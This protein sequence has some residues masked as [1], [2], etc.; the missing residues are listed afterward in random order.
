M[1]RTSVR[2][3][4]S[5]PTARW[6]ALLPDHAVGADRADDRVEEDHWIDPV[7]RAGLPVAH[8]LQHRVGD[9]GN[10]VG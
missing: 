10:Q 1:P 5:T 6:A 4:V 8:L 9:R 3:S 7:E 2:P